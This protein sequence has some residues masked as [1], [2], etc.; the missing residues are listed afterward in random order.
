MLLVGPLPSVYCVHL[1][2]I[3]LIVYGRNILTIFVHVGKSDKKISLVGHKIGNDPF[4]LGSLIMGAGF[5]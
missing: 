2:Y 1:T 3:C 4:S 5:G